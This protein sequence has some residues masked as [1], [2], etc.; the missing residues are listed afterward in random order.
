MLNLESKEKSG[1][2]QLES[3]DRLLEE[4][5]EI[6]HRSSIDITDILSYYQILF[7]RMEVLRA[8]N[9]GTELALR[10][11]NL[12]FDNH[13]KEAVL[14]YLDILNDHDYRIDYHIFCELP[15]KKIINYDPWS[16]MV[17]FRIYRDRIVEPLILL[18][19]DLKEYLEDT[20]RLLTQAIDEIENRITIVIPGKIKI[21]KEGSDG[22][23]KK[24]ILGKNL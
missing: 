3:L 12:T 1:R 7:E 13:P 19:P 9:I 22:H 14:H 21:E 4:K 11:S 15:R 17:T 10:D 16:T 23:N 8:L 20:K 6:R 5:I 18:Y 24:L 2:E